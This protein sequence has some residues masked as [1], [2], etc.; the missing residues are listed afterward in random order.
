V[1]APELVIDDLVEKAAGDQTLY[2]GTVA[3]PTAR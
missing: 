2:R 1:T 3:A